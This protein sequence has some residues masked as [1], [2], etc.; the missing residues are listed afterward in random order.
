M[1]NSRLCDTIRQ[2]LE[3]QGIHMTETE[4]AELY[5]S[6]L[7]NMSDILEQGDII[8]ISDFG[9]FWKNTGTIFFKP[10]DDILERI[11]TEK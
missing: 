6:V 11:N 4:V 9:S 8:D 10:S 2:N 1:N 5:T 7:V 3:L